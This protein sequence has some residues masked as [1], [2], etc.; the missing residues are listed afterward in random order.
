M[1][2]KLDHIRTFIAVAESGSLVDA[3]KILGKTP[4]AVSLV[5]KQFTE[6][7][8]DG[9]FETDRKSTLTTT[10]QFVLNQSR[11]ALKNFDE[12]MQTIQQHGRGEHGSVR[13]ASVPSF[14]TRLLPKIVKNFRAELPNV[15]L[16]LRDAD[17][18]SIS[19]AVREGRVDIGI[20][21]RLGATHDLKTELLLEEPFGV[22]CRQ[23]HP[24][25]QL[26]KPITWKQLS[27]QKSKFISN[28]LCQLIVASI[29]D[30]PANES[31]FHIHNTATLLSF[32]A[33]GFGI[34]LLPRSA[35]SDHL[36]LCFLRL[37]D[38]LAIRR[39]FI[40]Q[41]QLHELNPAAQ[42]FRAQIKLLQ[43]TY[44]SGDTHILKTLYGE[45]M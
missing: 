36:G 41:H 7:A 16:E 19:Q 3:G 23:D 44:K 22:V 25:V 42:A 15:N 29:L 1:T 28:G 14:S 30:F 27:T 45:P 38:R 31:N 13:V 40:M 10:G 2:F 21:S 26:K 33:E 17:S 35:V 43:Q 11:N 6:Q 24:L 37:K 20:A 39:L 8:G 32:V 34:T 18:D 12:T 4:S 9:L 5:L